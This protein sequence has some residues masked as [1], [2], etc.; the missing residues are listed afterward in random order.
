MHFRT[1]FFTKSGKSRNYMFSQET[2]QFTIQRFSKNRFYFTTGILN[3][4][5]DEAREWKNEY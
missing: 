1:M 4:S 3:V 5:G 2:Y